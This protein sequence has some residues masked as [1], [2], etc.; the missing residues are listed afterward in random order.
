MKLF[1]TGFLMMACVSI[2]RL[3]QVLCTSKI[4]FSRRSFSWV[5]LSEELS[6]FMPFGVLTGKTNAN[7]KIAREPIK[8]SS[9]NLRGFL[10]MKPYNVFFRIRELFLIPGFAMMAVRDFY[11][12]KIKMFC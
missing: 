4:I 8:R 12:P 7:W 9:M 5:V 6:S 11:I 3:W 10:P 1:L 2:S